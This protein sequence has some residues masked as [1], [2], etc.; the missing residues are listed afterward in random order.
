MGGKIVVVHPHSPGVFFN[1][2][3]EVKITGKTKESLHE[4]VLFAKKEGIKIAVENLPKLEGWSFGSDISKFSKL[5]EEMNSD[6]LGLCLDTGHALVKR[7]DS[8]LSANIMQC[9]K[10][11]IA[12]HIQDTDGKKDRHWIPGEGVIN[13]LQFF[14]TLEIVNYQGMLTL[15]VAGNRKIAVYDTN[16]V[17]VKAKE[18]IKKYLLNSQTDS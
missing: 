8:D 1:P 6:N 12:L 13:W 18:S 11:L 15:E 3:G 4:I 5:I 10:Y 9:G 2:R 16:N 17:L 7:E 14:K